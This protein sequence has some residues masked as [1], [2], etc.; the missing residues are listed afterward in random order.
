MSFI[1]DQ[2]WPDNWTAVTADGGRSAQFEHTIL[3]TEITEENPRGYELLTMRRGEPTM[4][5]DDQKFQ[6]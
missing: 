4:V 6:R 1:H 5:W 3:V 2:T